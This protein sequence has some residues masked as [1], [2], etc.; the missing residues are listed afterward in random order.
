MPFG[1]DL[2]P[3]LVPLVQ[4][5]SHKGISVEPLR[6]GVVEAYAQGK[7]QRV[8]V[9][10][11][12]LNQDRRHSPTFYLFRVAGNELLSQSSVLSYPM[13]TFRVRS[14]YYALQR[15]NRRATS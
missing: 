1:D 5:L 12:T 3:F 15:T 13:S 8:A 14:R 9:G 11:R 2:N 7:L 6:P 4:Q 10:T